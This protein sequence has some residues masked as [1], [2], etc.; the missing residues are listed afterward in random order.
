MNFLRKCKRNRLIRSRTRKNAVMPFHGRG[1]GHCPAHTAS[2]FVHVI[3]FLIVWG[4]ST[5]SPKLIPG[6]KRTGSLPSALERAQHL[7]ATTIFCVLC[8]F[9]ILSWRSETS[10]GVRNARRAFR[11]APSTCFLRLP[12][13]STLTCYTLTNPLLRATMMQTIFTALS[14]VVPRSSKHSWTVVSDFEQRTMSNE[15]QQTSCTTRTLWHLAALHIQF[16]L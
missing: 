13:A 9:G 4:P 5:W 14:K 11:S 15:A 3:G 7:F 8:D 6:F 2:N 1:A 10:A 16:R 12:P